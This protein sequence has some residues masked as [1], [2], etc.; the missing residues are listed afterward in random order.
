M[1]GAAVASARWVWARVEPELVAVV[2]LVLIAA[3]AKSV[4]P[5]TTRR[6]SR[7]PNG[8]IRVCVHGTHPTR[9]P[10]PMEV[11]HRYVRTCSNRY[12]LLFGI[13]IECERMTDVVEYDEAS[14]PR[15]R[16]MIHHTV[17]I[18][19]ENHARRLRKLLRRFVSG[20]EDMVVFVDARVSPVFGWDTHLVDATKD[21]KT[22]VTCP[23]CVH[24][25]AFPTLRRRSNG[26]VVRDEARAFVHAGPAGTFVASVCLCHEFVACHPMSVP[27]DSVGQVKVVVPAFPV[28]CAVAPSVEEDVLDHN[29]QVQSSGLTN[30]Q[31]LGLSVS[32]NGLEMYHKYGSASSARLAIKLDRT[33]APSSS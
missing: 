30:S 2:T 10:D 7:R 27:T 14:Y 25:C 13:L 9:G 18:D 15:D 20:M 12:D 33:P 6:P 3:V 11:V 29:L 16:V 21:A 5:R 26:E 8:T 1:S 17:R 23:L 22:V 28:V 24:A 31:R 4:F 19:A 32:P